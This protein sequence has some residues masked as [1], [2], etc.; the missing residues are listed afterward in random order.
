MIRTEAALLL[1]RLA[2][3]LI[4]FA[5]QLVSV[6]DRLR[7]RRPTVVPVLIPSP[8]PLEEKR[9]LQARL[10]RLD[11]HIGWALGSPNS[12]AP[13]AKTPDCRWRQ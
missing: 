7:V 11:M 8:E 1:C 3:A 2:E 4:Q 6:G 12:V 5:L 10:M 9:A 13:S